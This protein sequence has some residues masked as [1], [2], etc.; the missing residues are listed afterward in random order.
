MIIDRPMPAKVS[1]AR[2]ATT[3]HFS[4]SPI[5]IGNVVYVPEIVPEPSGLRIDLHKTRAP[6]ISDLLKEAT[7]LEQD[8][9][10]SAVERNDMLFLARKRNSQSDK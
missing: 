1:I 10:S 9:S 4:G 2:K 7:H 3:P 5:S 8:F 6:W